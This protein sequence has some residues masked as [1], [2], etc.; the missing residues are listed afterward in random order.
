MDEPV[1]QP[2]ARK[3]ERREQRGIR[4]RAQSVLAFS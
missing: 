4:F 2:L 1:A 3:L